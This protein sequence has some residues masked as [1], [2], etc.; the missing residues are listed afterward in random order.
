MKHF[1]VIKWKLDPHAQPLPGFKDPDPFCR[2]PRHW[3]DFRVQLLSTMMS[4]AGTIESACN[5][6]ML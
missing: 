5:Q 2:T 1:S 3:L 6:E 4:T